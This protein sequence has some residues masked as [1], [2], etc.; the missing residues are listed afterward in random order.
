[1]KRAL[2][3]DSAIPYGGIIEDSLQ[4]SIFGTFSTNYEWFK[5]EVQ[6]EKRFGDIL[7][8]FEGSEILTDKQDR[9]LLY[10][11]LPREVIAD[12]KI[13]PRRLWPTP[14][15]ANALSSLYEDFADLKATLYGTDYRGRF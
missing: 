2:A 12:G 4:N 9:A 11:N 3:F 13:T 7:G 6:A 8:F 15:E 5:R 10:F 14:G 1:M